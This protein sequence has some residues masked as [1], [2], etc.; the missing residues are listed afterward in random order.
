M[1]PRRSLRSG[2]MF[3]ILLFRIG[4]VRVK[5]GLVVTTPQGNAHQ[6]TSAAWT[7]DREGV[8]FGVKLGIMDDIE[9]FWVLERERENVTI[10]CSFPFSTLSDHE[11]FAIRR[12]A[13]KI[14]RKVRN[15]ARMTERI[16]TLICNPDL[17][18]MITTKPRPVR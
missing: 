12:G 1:E 6:A 13:R 5:R 7:I 17:V 4:E 18:E 8:F 14:C 9:A 2:A 11:K 16:L 15:E 3:L 10:S